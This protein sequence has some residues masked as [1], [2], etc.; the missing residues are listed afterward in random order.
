MSD[1][2]LGVVHFPHEG[3]TIP[4][5]FTLGRIAQMGRET[6]VMKLALATRG[7]EGDGQALADLLELASGGELKAVDLVDQVLGFDTALIALHDA[8][9]LSRFGPKGK[10]QG[11]REKN[12]LKR[13]WT[14]LKTLWRRVRGPA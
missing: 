11:Q 13:L 5:R 4:L 10:P 3:R 7:G 9:A 6:V 8:W 2:Y 12:P 14:S 1:A